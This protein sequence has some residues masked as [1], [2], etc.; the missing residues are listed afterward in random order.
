MPNCEAQ[1][2]QFCGSPVFED[3]LQL[4]QRTAQCYRGLSRTELAATLC[5]QLG[6]L[7]PSG[8]PKT[9]E[10]RQFMEAL[11][12]RDLVELPVQRPGRPKGS[13][14]RIAAPDSVP[15]LIEGTLATLRPIT[16]ERV[17]SPASH[18]RWRA[19]M[20]QYHYLGHR[21]PFGAH[22]R[23]H[24]QA[25]QGE[26]GGLQFSSP[27]WRLN[28]RDQR[29]GWDEAQRQRGLQHIVCNSRF[30]ILPG[31][32]VA[33][34]ASH[35]LAQAARQISTDWL[36]A[37]GVKPWLLETLVDPAR[38]RGV[39]Y[40]AANWIEAGLTSGRG[41]DDRTHQ[42]HGASPKQVWLY[43]LG[44]DAQQRLRGA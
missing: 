2:L 19:R 32:R 25:P 24:I 28:A 10:C 39:S 34:L 38:Y 36:E 37:F 41:R 4:I 42:R 20:E 29:I 18:A 40:R 35:V 8:K 23:Y 11:A 14:T 3:Q 17:T 44:R 12:E 43:P 26:L 16:L 33:H 6:W 5:E 15:M 1:G 7:R 27:A 22:L 13:T 21:V 31:V 9:V 30:L